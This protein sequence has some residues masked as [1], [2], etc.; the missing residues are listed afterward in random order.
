VDARK[1]KDA[2]EKLLREEVTTAIIFSIAR[3]RC[4]SSPPA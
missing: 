3:R 1:K 4:A 2:L